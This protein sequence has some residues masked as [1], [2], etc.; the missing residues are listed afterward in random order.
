MVRFD[1]QQL[2]ADIAGHG[3][4][5]RSRIIGS[6]TKTLGKNAILMTYEA[7]LEA[8]EGAE[9]LV[10]VSTLYERRDGQWTGV[11]RRQMPVRRALA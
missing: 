1:E 10:V 9:T 3:A 5:G 4:G 7:A 2:L 11:L 6:R 8:P